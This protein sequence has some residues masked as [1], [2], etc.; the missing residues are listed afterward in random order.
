MP[1]CRLA[2]NVTDTRMK[3]L[4]AALKV[5][6]LPILLSLLTACG[7][8]YSIPPADDAMAG[9]ASQ[10]FAEA[11][12]TPARALASPAT[13]EARF[14]RVAARVV[15]VG[16]QLC[17]QESANQ[18]NFR[19]DVMVEIDRTMPERNAYFTFVNEQPTIRMSLPMLQDAANDDEVAFIMSHE[20]GHLIGRHIHKQQQQQLAGALI[21][22]TM[23]AVANADAAAAGQTYDPANVDR[24]MEIG[25]AVG[26]I[27]YSQTYELES[28]MLGTRIASAAGYDALVAAK[29]FARPEDARSQSG[30][31]LSF[32]GTHPSNDKRLATVIATRAQI[33]GQVPLARKQR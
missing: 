7:T 27:A 4:S 26:S 30:T 23:A 13:G 28:D 9:T 1:A 29:F 6:S 21:L 8:T 20:F 10:M 22:G 32:W 33:D 16:R 24:A 15:S 5:L 25:A 18:K 31:K 11:R 17:Q 19:C 12:S 14:A 2:P 3:P